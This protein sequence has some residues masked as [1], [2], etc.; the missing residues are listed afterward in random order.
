[1]AI[2]L[3]RLPQPLQLPQAIRVHPSGGDGAQP[4]LRDKQPIDLVE[5]LRGVHP[6]VLL[7]KAGEGGH[8]HPMLDR[9]LCSQRHDPAI[10]QRFGEVGGETVNFKGKLIPQQAGNRRLVSLTI[11]FRQEEGHLRSPAVVHRLGGIETEYIRAEIQ[12]GSRISQAGVMRLKDGF[13]RF[14]IEKAA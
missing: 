11:L 8:T 10:R 9:T 13:D 3:Q 5:R 12:A 2:P 7:E 14:I 4:L 6:Q 1:M